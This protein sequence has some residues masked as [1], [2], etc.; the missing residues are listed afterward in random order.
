MDFETFWAAVVARIESKTGEDLSVCGYR[1]CLPLPVVK[2][3]M[4]ETFDYA[5]REGRVE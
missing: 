2:E 4:R 1:F 3:V 5:A